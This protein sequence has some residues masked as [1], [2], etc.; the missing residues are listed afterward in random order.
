[1]PVYTLNMKLFAKGISV[2]AYVVLRGTNLLYIKS[3]PKKI[4]ILEIMRRFV[5]LKKEI[6]FE[7]RPKHFGT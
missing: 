7:F 3:Q 2:R 1:M 4:Q 6:S 5:S